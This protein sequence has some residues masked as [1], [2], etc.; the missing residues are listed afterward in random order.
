MAEQIAVPMRACRRRAILKQREL[1]RQ[2]S[3]CRAM[4]SYGERNKPP[5][6]S[7]EAPVRDPRERATRTSPRMIPVHFLERLQE[8]RRSNQKTRRW[9]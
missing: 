1:C 4:L 2:R 5:S 7:T 3:Q 8:A 9:N 6:A